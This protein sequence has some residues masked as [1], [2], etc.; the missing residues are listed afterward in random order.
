MTSDFG[1]LFVEYFFIGWVFSID[2]SLS[3]HL[4]S[5]TQGQG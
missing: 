2:N 1:E 4:L 5:S 3:K